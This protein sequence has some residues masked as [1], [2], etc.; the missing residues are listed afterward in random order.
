MASVHLFSECAMAIR[1]LGAVLETTPTLH[2]YAQRLPADEARAGGCIVVD[3]DE[4]TGWW[5]AILAEAIAR[6]QLP[7]V[8]VTR[9]AVVRDVVLALR[10]GARDVIDWEAD[11]EELRRAVHEFAA[12]PA[13]RSARGAPAYR[14]D[15]LTSRQREILALAATGLPTKAIARAL[16]LSTRTVE[17]HR[18]RMVKRLMAGSFLELVRQQIR[19]EA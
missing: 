16:A 6:P 5:R 3:M 10:L 14:L 9:T 7:I 18:A 4:P 15:R 17:A 2:R 13:R 11:G 8:L 19:C 12:P 1:G